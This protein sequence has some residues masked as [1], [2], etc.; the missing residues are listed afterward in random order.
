VNGSVSASTKV[1]LDSV[2]P[3]VSITAPAN[4]SSFTTDRVNVS[5]IFTESS[6]QQIT[7]NG[8]RAFSSGNTFEA[9]NI[10]LAEGADTITAT[11]QS[12]W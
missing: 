3:V 12:L 5:G 11:A 7:V 4:N 10:V 8:V 2:A 6:L 9:L 1:Y